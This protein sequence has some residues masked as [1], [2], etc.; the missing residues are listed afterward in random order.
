MVRAP[1]D[2]PAPPYAWCI[3]HGS[4]ATRPR[5]GILGISYRAMFSD[6]LGIYQLSTVNG[7]IQVRVIQQALNTGPDW[8]TDW[9]CT[10][11]RYRRWAL[12]HDVSL[13]R[14]WV[15]VSGCPNTIRQFCYRNPFTYMMSNQYHRSGA[16]R[17][18]TTL[19]LPSTLG[20]F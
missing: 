8:A 3:H 4:P 15:G 6:H 2:H 10:S 1:C 5:M 11:P 17:F 18:R 9:L 12:C 7:T 14:R 16:F 19:S 20:L 13:V